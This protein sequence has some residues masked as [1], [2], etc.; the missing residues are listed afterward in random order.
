MTR[1]TESQLDEYM[2][3]RDR[4]SPLPTYHHLVGADPPDEGPESRLQSKIQAWAKEWGRPIQSNRQSSRAKTLLTPGWP[5]IVLILPQGRVLFIELKGK[6]GRLTEEQKQMKL[7][8]M[9]LGHTIHEIRSYRA[10]ISLVLGPN[11]EQA[12]LKG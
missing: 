3:K 7:M 9:A 11:Q 5:D 4:L 1:W 12:A 8:F 2:A 6:R 10:F